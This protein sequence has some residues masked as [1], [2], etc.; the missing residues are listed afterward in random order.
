MPSCFSERLKHQLLIGLK[1]T[2]EGLLAT[3]ASD[4]W[5]MY[6]GLPRPCKHVD[7]I[8]NHRLKVVVVRESFIV[9]KT[10]I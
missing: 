7:S 8:L 1:T 4:V 6:G 2:V 9:L 5:G 3:N 10:Q